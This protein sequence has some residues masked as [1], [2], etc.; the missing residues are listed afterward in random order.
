MWSSHNDGTDSITHSYN[1]LNWSSTPDTLEFYVPLPPVL[2]WLVYSKYLPDHCLGANGWWKK[3]HALL[4]TPQGP[5]AYTNLQGSW[6]YQLFILSL[7]TGA[8]NVENYQ[9]QEGNVIIL[10]NHTEIPLSTSLEHKLIIESCSFVFPIPS[11]RVKRP[12]PKR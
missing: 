4:P 11:S 6:V 8:H 2:Q 1:T 5:C 9:K 7:E 12:Y 10:Y 3:D